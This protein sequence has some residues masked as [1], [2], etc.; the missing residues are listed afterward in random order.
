MTR[1][2]RGLQHLLGGWLRWDDV[3]GIVDDPTTGGIRHQL[4]V[5][6]RRRCRRIAGPRRPRAVV[7]DHDDEIDEF[8]RT[9]DERELRGGRGLESSFG[10]EEDVELGDDDDDD[11]DDALEA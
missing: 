11:D 1:R 2:V 7:H 5:A 10:D 6:A 3:D 9:A 8:R 4:G